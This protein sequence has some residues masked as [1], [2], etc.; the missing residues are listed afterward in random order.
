MSIIK[1]TEVG[2]QGRT[3]LIREDFNVPVKN[4]QVTSAARIKAALFTI[5]TAVAAGAKVSS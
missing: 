3:V 2:L 4:G 1:M 5:E